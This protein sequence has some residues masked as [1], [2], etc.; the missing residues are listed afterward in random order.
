LSLN[1]SDKILREVTVFSAGDSSKIK[2]WANVP[3]FFT[4]TLIKQGIIVHRINIEPPLLLRGIYKVIIFPLLK[5]FNKRSVHYYYRT[6]VNILMQQLKFKILSKKYPSS[7]ANIFIPFG[8][9]PIING[10]QPIVLFGDWTYAYHFAY[11]DNRN[12]D[13][14][15][16]K[17]I[18]RE[19]KQIENADLVISLFPGITRYMQNYYKNNN[20]KY[21]GNVINSLVVPNES[22]IIELRKTSMELLFIGSKKYING[23]MQLI[24]SF[25][26]LKEKIPNLVLN[27]IGI[28]DEEIPKLPEDVKC[29]GYL[30][31]EFQEERALYYTL[32]KQARVFINTAS[33]WGAFSASLEALY[34]YLPVI[35]SPYSEF[36][37][38]FGEEIDF[39]IYCS[40]S[41][42]ESIAVQI[43]NILNNNRY[44]EI[45]IKA[46]NSVLGY[47]WP[48]YMDKV[49]KSI[50]SIL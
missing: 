30:N 43:E 27:V 44:H 49:I 3:F 31:K 41:S 14:L 22:E 32:L 47:T 34:F 7:Q 45:C 50:E 23:L 28:E 8:V 2:T 26:L 39:G 29:Y 24:R 18:M 48:I 12:P 33:A 42:P 5:L 4:E 38:T 10:N 20:I 37:E 13:F 21:L 17:G 11:F 1:E 46:H 16:K 9:A 40:D 25:E 15:E 19:D 6:K 35:V 36:V